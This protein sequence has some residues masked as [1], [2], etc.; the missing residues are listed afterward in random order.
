MKTWDLPIARNP[1]ASRADLEA[2]LGQILEPLQG[3]L[4]R[5]GS[6]L[7]A[8]NS[9]A[10]YDEIAALLEGY[11]RLLWGLAPLAAGGGGSSLLPQILEGLKAGTD[12]SGPGFWGLGA[13][14]DQ[15]F[16]EMAAISLALLIAPETFWEPL[17]ELERGRLC[18]WLAT[19]NGVELP[20][21]NWEFFRV[22]ANCA[23]RRLSRPHDAARLAKGLAEI[24]GM[25][26]SEGWYIDEATYDNYNPFA[27]HFYGLVYAALMEAEDPGRCL[28]YRKRARLFA[29]SYL[30]WFA[31]DGSAIAHGRS[32][33]YRFAASSFFSACAFAG[34]EVLPWGQLKGLVLRNLRWWF[35][36]PIFDHEGLL[37]IGY[38]Y[39]NLLMAEQYNA[40]G[41]PYWALKSY[42]VLALPE[43]HPFW[44]AK[45]EGLPPQPAISLNAPPALLVCRDGGRAGPAAP[46]GSAGGEHLYA[47][48]AGQYPRYELVQAAAK[49]A[50]FAYSNRFG[51]CVSHGGYDLPKLGCDSMLVLS[52][53]DGYWRER[54][55]TRDRFACPDFVKSAWSPWPDVEI[56]TWLL[57]FGAW[58]LRVHAI[59]SARSLES[60][61]GGFSLPD[62]NAEESA[63][64]PAVEG[65]AG[66]ILA[67]MPWASGAIVDLSPLRPAGRAAELHKPEPNLNVMHP[68]VFVPLLRGRIEKGRSILACAVFASTDAEAGGPGFWEGA[69]AFSYD[70]ASGVGLASL[71]QRRVE[72]EIGPGYG[73]KP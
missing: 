25:Y 20:P 4:V 53:G 51:F 58:H 16:V 69:P 1:L 67:I 50:K 43:T 30:P 46:A 32:L 6:G 7:H 12:P 28:E 3:R 11:S 56:L 72:L 39:P 8:G 68:K 57:P 40:P 21:N 29:A 35:A 27:F 48:A 18:D 14:R 62:Q 64:K 37:T 36:E 49:Y 15:R 65:K 61:E 52:E 31:R 66:S 45:E 26:R 59:A 10:H 70:S 60:A 38:R 22:L 19:I 44:A 5:G 71:G 33:T 47:L 73:G 2:S 54:R 42:L 13:D 24:D 9:S 34:E 55:H 23:L 41:S 63:P 17:S